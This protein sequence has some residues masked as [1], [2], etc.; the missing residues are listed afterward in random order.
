MVLGVCPA[1][2]VSRVVTPHA[3]GSRVVAAGAVNAACVCGCCSLAHGAAA[4]SFAVHVG[5]A[6][7]LLIL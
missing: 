1:A 7:Y 3:D 5:A 6:S 4:A 2:R